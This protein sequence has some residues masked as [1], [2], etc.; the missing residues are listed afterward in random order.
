MPVT[1]PAQL[2]VVVG[3]ALMVAEHWPVTSGNT[4][5]AGAVV[6]CTTMFCVWVDTLP[7]PSSK[8]QCTTKVPCVECVSGSVV[9]PVIAPLQLSVAVGGAA[10]R[11]RA[12]A[13]R[14][15][16]A[17]RIWHR[18][19]RIVHH[20]VLRLGGH[21]AIA[22]IEVPSHHKGALRRMRERVGRRAGNRA[23][24]IVR[25]RRWPADRCRALAGRS[26]KLPAFGTG[27]VVSCTTMF[28]VWV[29]TLPLPSSKCQVTTKVPCVECVSGSVVVP[30]IAPLQ[31]SV[32]VGGP[33]IV[34]EHWP[35]ASGKVATSG[36]GAVVSCTTTFCV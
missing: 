33:L 35:V 29:D 9:V 30:V 13:G 26:G 24:A 21:V 19:R 25:R 23:A 15:R 34:A 5:V 7:L 12:L 14:I 1:V 28:C 8:C 11:C 20:D 36:T 6:S 17:A 3:A 22:I 18:G 27:A 2:S 31:L 4:G 16:Q 32:A 10:D